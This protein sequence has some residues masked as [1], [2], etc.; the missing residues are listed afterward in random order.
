MGS[1]LQQLMKGRGQMLQF[2]TGIFKPQ[3]GRLFQGCRRGVTDK[4]IVSIYKVP[5]LAVIFYQFRIEN[6]VYPGGF[7]CLGWNESRLKQTCPVEELKI[8][9]VE[10]SYI[11][12][13]GGGYYS[14]MCFEHPVSPLQLG[15]GKG[16]LALK[17]RCSFPRSFSQQI[18]QYRA[19][20]AMLLQQP[21][22]KK[23]SEHRVC[24]Q[25][26][27]SRRELTLLQSVPGDK[28]IAPDG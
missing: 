19:S 27:L 16:Q 2:L 17:A 3:T 6:I 26:L 4:I 28:T 12:V 7:P 11:M 24:R 9:L 14:R 22:G 5:V 21:G 25:P 1:P 23:Q 18:L 10:S 20:V 8:T 15:Q 13:Q